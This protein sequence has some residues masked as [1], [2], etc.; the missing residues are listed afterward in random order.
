MSCR[1]LASTSPSSAMYF[2]AIGS[3]STIRRPGISPAGTASRRRRRGRHPLRRPR[4]GSSPPAG[5]TAAAAPSAAPK[6]P[7]RKS[8]TEAG[9]PGGW[10]PHARG[11][12]PG[13]LPTHIL[14]GA[15]V[16][17][18]VRAYLRVRAW[19]VEHAGDGQRAG[20]AHDDIHGF[21]AAL[22]RAAGQVQAAFG[23][24]RPVE[25]E[26]ERVA[27]IADAEAGRV[28]GVTRRADGDETA[29]GRGRGVPEH[30]AAVDVD[31]A[32][33]RRLAGVAAS[34]EEPRVPSVGRVRDADPPDQHRRAVRRAHAEE[35]PGDSGRAEEPRP[36]ATA[37][38]I[39]LGEDRGPEVEVVGIG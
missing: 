27:L 19:A 10:K 26:R 37:L 36:N 7:E 20:L 34:R 2:P 39:D 29:A 17:E 14:R 3:I 38:R 12:I 1:K 9:G 28:L 6:F 23:A 8:I 5:A 31:R 32:L 22:A 24:A 25:D 4:P 18:A 30:V 15:H 13:L 11:G 16:E 21:V 33:E 35:S